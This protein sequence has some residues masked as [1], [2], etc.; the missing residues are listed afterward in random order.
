[1]DPSTSLKR[2][3]RR[4]ARG[5]PRTSHPAA[6]ALAL[7]LLLLPVAINTPAA[8]SKSEKIIAEVNQQL[9]ARDRKAFAAYRQARKAYNRRLSTYWRKV[10]I[11]RRNRSKKRRAKQALSRSDFILSF[12]PKYSGPKLAKHIRK[13]W[14]K[15]RK[16]YKPKKPPREIP[17]LRSFLTNAK[18][19]YG[20]VPQ[21][22]SE[23]EFKRRYAREALRLGLKKSHVVR[24]YAFETG[25]RGTSDMQAG[26][27]PIK[28][29]GRPISTALGYAQLLAANSVSELVKHGS[30]FVT[31]LKALAAH[32]K[33]S[34]K[35]KAGLKKKI[36][37]LQAMRRA[38]RSVKND[39][40]VHRRLAKTGRGLGIHAINL[41]GDIGPWLQVIKLKGIQ[42]LARKWGMTTFTGAELE[43]MNLAGPRTG[44][45]MLQPWARNIPTTNFFARAAYYRNSVVRERTASQLLKEID[46]RMTS[47]MRYKGAKQ[48]AKA[49]DYVIR[50]AHRR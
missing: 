34:S 43:M 19:H 20:F 8:A 26:I 45:E 17:G 1:M 49:F 24:I 37:A 16:K 13:L 33:I 15:I 50:N 42:K 18:R 9:N 7:A 3:M 29:T 36:K 12:P 28:K 39:W 31:R 5:F 25:G 6:I 30:S 48:F 27:H 2:E 47:Y 44:F 21:R 4:T 10:A 32:P 11:K 38:A 40:Y 41:D 23:T 14:S 22:I 35:R 46:R